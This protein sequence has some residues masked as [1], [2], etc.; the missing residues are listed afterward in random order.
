MRLPVQIFI[1]KALLYLWN[2]GYKCFTFNDIDMIPN[3]E[4]HA[5]ILNFQNDPYKVNFRQRI[6]DITIKVAKLLHLDQANHY[7]TNNEGFKWKLI[8]TKL[9]VD[10]M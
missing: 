9:K 6:R 1:G 3:I 2:L 4:E 5:Q 10:K 8:K 7:R